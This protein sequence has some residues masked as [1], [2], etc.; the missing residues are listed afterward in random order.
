MRNLFKERA[1]KSHDT[2]THENCHINERRNQMTTITIIIVVSVGLGL[3][4]IGTGININKK[5]ARGRET[6][7]DFPPVPADLPH[8]TEPETPQ[9]TEP[10]TPQQT[11]PETLQQTEPETLQQTE[12]ETLQQTEPE[13]L[14]Q[15]EPETLQQTEPETPQQKQ[16]SIAAA[17]L[18]AEKLNGLLRTGTGE[19]YLTIIAV[20]VNAD[21]MEYPN[22]TYTTLKKAL[23]EAGVQLDLKQTRASTMLRNLQDCGVL[24]PSEVQTGKF[25]GRP[26]LIDEETARGLGIVSAALAE[27]VT[28]ADDSQDTK[29]PEQTEQPDDQQPDT[30][31]ETEQSPTDPIDNFSFLVDSVVKALVEEHAT[32]GDLDTGGK[33]KSFI[34]TLPGVTKQNKEKIWFSLR[35]RKAIVK[36]TGTD[37]AWRVVLPD[38]TQS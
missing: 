6:I 4:L 31:T 18:D 35:R 25:V 13:T 19:D 22:W 34:L 2:M 37:N 3:I 27:E 33:I 28:I 23:A 9:Q 21:P 26:L 24:G 16:P 5:K 17:V 20:M 8:E 12:P 15:T 10:E 36:G 11:E 38:A 14:Q 29:P 30:E 7:S 32:S 1:E